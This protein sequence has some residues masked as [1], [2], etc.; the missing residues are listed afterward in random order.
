MRPCEEGESLV[1]SLTCENVLD[2]N[3]DLCLMNKNNVGI[4]MCFTSVFVATLNLSHKSSQASLDRSGHSGDLVVHSCQPVLLEFTL[5][6][7]KTNNWTLLL[8]SQ[9]FLIHR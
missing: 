5:N 7:P 6:P 9:K 8:L 4:T 3:C 2:C 1:A